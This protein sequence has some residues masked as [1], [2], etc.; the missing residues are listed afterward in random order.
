MK[1]N[2]YISLLW[3]ILFLLVSFNSN[4]Q[5]SCT[6]YTVLCYGYYYIEDNSPGDYYLVR[7][8][9]ID[10]CPSTSDWSTYYMTTSVNTP[11]YFQNISVSNV[12]IPNESESYYFYQIWVQ[13]GKF[14]GTYPNGTLVETE[15]NY[16][17]AGK[18]YS[19]PYYHLTVYQDYDPIVV[20]FGD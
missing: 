11:E 3:T 10:D 15:S 9:V 20:K 2:I 16:G 12:G 14:T 4:A 8:Q 6:N 1:K 17:Y 19:F 13:V 5:R 7:Y 18:T